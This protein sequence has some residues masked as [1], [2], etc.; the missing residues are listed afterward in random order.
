MDRLGARLVVRHR[1]VAAVVAL[2]AILGH[3]L[4]VATGIHVGAAQPGSLSNSGP[5]VSGLATLER[6]G[7]PTGTINP[8]EVLVARGEPR[9][10][11]QL[12]SAPRRLHVSG[13]SDLTGAPGRHRHR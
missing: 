3:S 1:V 6:D 5:A 4:A 8:V 12:G 11:A 13:S 9:N 10:V 7:F 2:C